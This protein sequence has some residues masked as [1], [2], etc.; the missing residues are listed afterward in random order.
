MQQ[1]FQFL[2]KN[3]TGLLFIFLSSVCFIF[4]FSNNPY[5]RSKFLSA[6]NSISGAYYEKIS[7]FISYF[8]LKDEVKEL[9]DENLI[10]KKELFKNNN[11]NT[12]SDIKSH[13][14]FEI[15]QSKII[16]N[17]YDTYENYLTINSGKNKNIEPEMG[18]MNTQGIIGVIEFTSNNY[19]S[20]ISILNRNSKINA[21]LKNSEHF[22]WITWNGKS[23]GFVQLIDMPRLATVRQ[24][25]T[26]VTGTYGVFFP[27]NQNIGTV[28]KIYTDGETNF[29]TIDV[30]LFNDMTKLKNVF[31]IK[32]K[33]K[34]EIK[35]IEK[36]DSLQTKLN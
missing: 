19:S 23:T 29:F 36:I 3:L 22:G 31:A 32:N 12:I 35:M 21:K 15:I 1:F 11:F 16:K 33:D 28:H 27:E 8:E 25:D 20:V 7:N 13:K 4:I 9:K 24:G 5:Q 14:G 34:N 17:S 18:V 10:L 2:I 6:S 30:K 26:I